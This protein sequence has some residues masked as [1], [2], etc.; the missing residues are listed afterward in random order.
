MTILDEVLE[1]EA[2]VYDAR[3]RNEHMRSV[4]DRREHV[5]VG[6]AP[7]MARALREI[8]IEAD[9]PRTKPAMQLALS[10][11][12]IILARLDEGE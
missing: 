8:A 4:L 6:A 11:I 9:V 10:R 12:R 2:A 3:A 5:H 7:R 1:A